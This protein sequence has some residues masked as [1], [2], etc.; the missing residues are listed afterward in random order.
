MMRSSAKDAVLAAAA[1]GES[2]AD[3]PLPRA[4]TPLG[5][6]WRAIAAGGQGRYAAAERDLATLGR[7][8]VGPL[9]SLA[10]STGASFRRQL[11]WHDAARSRDGRAWALADGDAEAGLDAL[12]GLAADALGVGRFAA[13][14]ALLGRAHRVLSDS[15]PLPARLPLR[16]AWVAA[17]LAMVSGDGP[18]AVNHARAA[19]DLAAGTGVGARHRVKTAMVVA[20]AHCSTGDLDTARAVADDALAQTQRYGLIPLRWA[21]ASLLAD[22]G[23]GELA[24]DD[25]LAVRDHCAD[26][27][28]ASGGSWRQR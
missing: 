7:V 13:S 24:R 28:R 3:W 6:W 19:S 20:A 17:E 9:S 10:H 26:A 18:A 23:S 11:G 27:V 4:A 22:I 16:M 21:L 5:L 2:A 8:A 15:G 14:E 12:V 25:L 1:F